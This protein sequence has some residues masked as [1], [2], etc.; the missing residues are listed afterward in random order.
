MKTDKQIREIAINERLNCSPLDYETWFLKGWRA[1]EKEAM[2]F[3]VNNPGIL[4]DQIGDIN[5]KFNNPN[6]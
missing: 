5:D 2:E 1:C 3:Y 4:K 6:Q